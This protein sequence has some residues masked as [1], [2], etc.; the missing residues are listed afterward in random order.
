[1]DYLTAM[2]AF[3]RAAELGGFSRAAAALGVETSSVSRHVQAL[4]RDLGVAL[5]NRTTR[6]LHLT[7]AGTSFY[8]RA[9]RIVGDVAE[10]RAVAAAF[11]RKAQGLLRLRVPIAFGRRHVAPLLPEFLGQYPDIRIDLAMADV[12]GD[13]IT[14]GGDLAIRIGAL[15]DSTLKA[16]K[17]APHRRV[18]CASPEY[19][20]RRPPIL[21]PADLAEHNCLLSTFAQ[22][23]WCFRG[24]EG[25]P[26]DEIPVS[27]NLRSDDAEVLLEATLGGLGPALLPTWLAGLDLQTGRLVRVLPDREVRMSPEDRAIYGVHPPKPVVALKVRLFLDFLGRRFGRPPYWDRDDSV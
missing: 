21:V 7:E 27:G 9:A 2:T 4:E 13:L 24:R 1:M 5:F 15:P 25:A 18:V 19:L 17:L 11:N 8:D 20:R 22:E 3:V 16:K 26:S 12:A 6:R 23:T 14:T 10:A